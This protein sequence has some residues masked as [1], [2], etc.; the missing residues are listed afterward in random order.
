[1][2]NIYLIRHGEVAW[3]SEGAYVGSTDIPLNDTGRRQAELLAKRLGSIE[4]ST[5]YSS[6]LSRAFET[7]RIIGAAQGIDPI[8]DR[9]FREID[10]GIWEGLS[11]QQILETYPETFDQWRKSAA[12]VVIPGGESI[13]HM[14]QRSYSAFLEVISSHVDG[15]IAIIA[16]KSVNRA[17][18]CRILSIPVSNYRTIGQAN[19][20]VNAIHIRIDDSIVV[21][22]INDRCHLLE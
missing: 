19:S 10:Y 6:D 22:T 18:L 16:H 3:N 12:E 1:M 13:N 7:A 8:P 5:I 21:D 14:L 20:C 15:N 2:K 9:C 17:I 11:E 4:I